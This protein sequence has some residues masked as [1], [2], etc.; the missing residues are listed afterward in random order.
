MVY[1][2]HLTNQESVCQCSPDHTMTIKDALKKKEIEKLKVNVIEKTSPEVLI[3]ADS[4]GLAILKIHA[5][6]S[7]K[8][9]VG[10]GAMLYKPKIQGDTLLAMDYSPQIVKPLQIKAVQQ[11]ALQKL[12]KIAQNDAT[13]AFTTLED[14][15]LVP[16]KSKALPEIKKFIAYITFLSTEKDSK[17]GT[18]KYAKFYDIMGEMGTLTIVGK[19]LDSPLKYK[20]YKFVFLAKKDSDTIVRL[21]TLEKTLIQEPEDEEV[22]LFKRVQVGESQLQ[23]TIKVIHEIYLPNETDFCWAML[24]QRSADKSEIKKES[25]SEEKK[26]EDFSAKKNEGDQANNELISIQGSSK[27]ILKDIQ[28]ASD[29]EEE[30]KEIEIYE[31][32]SEMFLEK[33]IEIT[34]ETVNDKLYTTRIIVL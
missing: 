14:I 26:D 24:I 15:K 5:D 6:F 29:I 3:V 2:D 7:K 11:G 17:Y 32:L 12:K 4:T 16:K 33:H 13:K 18:Y 30:D 1:K 19:H 25:S 28:F 34:Y 9:H 10:K 8:L 31:A 22:L 20:P 21:K 27:L 23:G